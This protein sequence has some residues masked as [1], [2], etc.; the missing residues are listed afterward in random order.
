MNE[1]VKRMFITRMPTDAPVHR[2]RCGVIDAGHEQG[3]EDQSH[4]QLAETTVCQ[5]ERR[6]GIEEAQESAGER[7]CRNPPGTVRACETVPYRPDD[8]NGDSAQ[9]RHYGE[10]ADRPGRGPEVLRAV[11]Q[12]RVFRGHGPEAFADD[13]VAVAF[14]I[15]LVVEIIVG[16]IH[17]EVGAFH[18]EDGEYCKDPAAAGYAD[19][20]DGGE[21]CRHETLYAGPYAGVGEPYGQFWEQF[22]HHG[23][24]A[25]VV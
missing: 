14:H 15:H 3:A 9:C 8:E 10:L 11:R 1:W 17:R 16:E 6:R 13:P 25:S 5:L 2:A 12:I 22:L 23:S 7:R 4:H 21:C 20:Q 19:C 24:Y 18:S